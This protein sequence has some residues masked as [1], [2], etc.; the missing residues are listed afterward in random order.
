MKFS[1]I[2]FGCRVNQADSLHIE[3]AL[4]EAGGEPSSADAADLVLRPGS[5][6]NREEASENFRHTGK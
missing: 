1:I 2:T 4:R 6:K 5:V 3:E